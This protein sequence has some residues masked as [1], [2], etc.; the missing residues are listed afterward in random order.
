VTGAGSGT[1]DSG[2]Q[3]DDPAAPPG[4]ASRGTLYCDVSASHPAAA[5]R[6]TGE[7]GADTVAAL[8]G[9]LL[10]LIRTRHH[11]LTIDVNGLSHVSPVCVGVLNRA[12]AELRRLGGRLTL[13]GVSD[14]ESAALRHAGLDDAIR[15]VVATTHPNPSARHE[16]QARSEVKPSKY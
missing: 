5:V 12:A 10:A 8:G 4:G 2:E 1:T 9:E 14:S 11:Q 7:L 13:S 16:W 15:L 3:I 6:L